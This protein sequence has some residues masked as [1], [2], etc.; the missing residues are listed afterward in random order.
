MILADTHDEL[1]RR[2]NLLLIKANTFISLMSLVF[3]LAGFSLSVVCLV[4]SLVH[5]Y[6]DLLGPL[7]IVSLSS[8]AVALA[9]VLLFTGIRKRRIRLMNAA[10]KPKMGV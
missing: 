1:V 7:R 10:T 3:A 4:F 6:A 8:N 9:L 2:H 5:L